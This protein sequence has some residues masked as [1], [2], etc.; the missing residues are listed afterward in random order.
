MI[1]SLNQPRTQRNGLQ[2]GHGKRTMEFKI[3]T[4]NVMSL[5]RNGACQ[6]L[7]EVLDVYK[8][9]VSGI[10]EVR[11]AG[12]GQLKVGKYIISIGRFQR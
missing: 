3:A 1:P 9:K 10:Q 2:I 5:F 6:N 8:I 7:G 4:W 12:K 11:W